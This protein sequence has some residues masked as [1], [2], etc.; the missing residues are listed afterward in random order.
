MELGGQETQVEAFAQ[1]VPASHCLQYDAPALAAMVPGAQAW[2]LCDEALRKV[3]EAQ[4]CAG[5]GSA[6]TDGGATTALVTPASELFAVCCSEETS[7]IE[8][9]AV[10]L[11]APT[12]AAGFA[13]VTTENTTESAAA[14]SRRAAAEETLTWM[15]AA[16]TFSNVASEASSVVFSAG[17]N[18]DTP[19]KEMEDDTVL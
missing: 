16:L 4:G 14:A 15:A 11:M 19:A 2:Q 10:L 13:V 6:V 18:E 12:M 17:P 7:E 5:S 1:T 8:K 3:P 9:D